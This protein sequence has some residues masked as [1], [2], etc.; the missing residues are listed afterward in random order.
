MTKSVITVLQFRL[1]FFI[2]RKTA[3]IFI[4]RLFKQALV[5]RYRCLSVCDGSFCIGDLLPSLFKLS[6]ALGKL[7]FS[8][9]DLLSSFGNLQFGVRYLA[10][11]IFNL[12]FAVCQ[13][14]FRIGNLLFRVR[15]LCHGVVIKGIRSGGSACKTEFLDFF[16]QISNACI[17]FTAEGRQLIK[18]LTADK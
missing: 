12:R 2:L 10:L 7:L 1:F 15:N 5:F 4:S 3:I 8:I 16:R 6:Q 11:G 18:S 9:T 17:V 13:P 14:G